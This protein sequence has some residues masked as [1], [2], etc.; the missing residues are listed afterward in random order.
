MEVI[1]KGINDGTI[2]ANID[3]NCLIGERA[4]ARWKV[5]EKKY[6]QVQEFSG[7]NQEIKKNPAAI[8]RDL[9][10]TKAFLLDIFKKSPTAE[11]LKEASKNRVILKWVHYHKITPYFVLLCPHIDKNQSWGVDLKLYE[12]DITEEVEDW[13]KENFNEELDTDQTESN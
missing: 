5:W 1:L 13:F 2:H 3:P 6:K 11:D 9:K 12:K 10:N 7:A 8:I 4:W